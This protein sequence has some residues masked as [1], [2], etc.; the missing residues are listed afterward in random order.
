MIDG[1]S[2]RF[3]FLIFFILIAVGGTAC[4]VAGG[5]VAYQRLGPAALDPLVAG[6][7]VASFVMWGFAAYVGFLFDENVAKPIQLLT[8]VM[9]DVVHAKGQST[10]N[11]RAV[12]YLGYLGPAVTDAI[13]ALRAAREEVDAAVISAT[14]ETE[15]QKGR[16]EALI[17]DLQLGVVIC[18]LDHQVLLFNQHALRLLH[19][20]GEVG[21]GRSL[22]AL[23]SGE[24]FRHALERLDRRFVEGRHA[25]HDEGL[26]ALVVCATADGRHTLQGRVSL[27]LDAGLKAPIGYI[28]VFDDVTQTLATQAKRDRLLHL[29]IEDLRRPAANLQ[30]AVE[31]LTGGDVDA[32]TREAFEQVLLDETTALAGRLARL[33][34]ES[35]DLLEGAWPMSDV[36]SSTLFACLEARLGGEGNVATKVVGEPA[37]LCCDSLTIVELIRHLILRLAGTREVE[38]VELQASAAASRVY[39]DI[40]WDGQVVPVG[41]IDRWLAEPLDDRL[42]GITGRDVMDRHKTEFWCE[43]AGDGARLRL[44]L[45]AARRQ[46]LGGYTLAAPLPSRPEFYDFDLLRRLNAAEGADAPLRQLSFVV[47]DTETTGLNPTQGDEIVSIAGVRIVNGRVLRGETFMSYVNPRRAIPAVS[48]KVHGITNAMVADAPT[49]EHVLPRFSAFAK[50]AVLV[51]H[52]AAFDLKFVTMKEAACGV[53]FDH[54]VLDT[55]LLAALVHG[56]QD[57]LT[58]DALAERYGVVLPPQERHTALGDAVA[59]AEVFLRLVDVL[60]TADVTTLNDALRASGRVAA[61]RRQQARY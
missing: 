4:I 34:E 46:H 22:F 41:T 27:I 29:A 20:S 58:L 47:F 28:A 18:N 25:E 26:S 10:V 39:L 37:W 14:A 52:N 9:R 19:V 8:R 60:A 35:R 48:T 40:G 1:W 3:R 7:V 6:A 13:D 30:A 21:L 55:V 31:V 16:L 33:E 44:P 45:A 59:T 43:R 24:P 57:S 49:I 36:F 11:P 61:I 23:V 53:R 2:L 12:R 5:W 42:G 54:P 15:R 51:A 17:R 50:D 38:N 56:Q 32:A